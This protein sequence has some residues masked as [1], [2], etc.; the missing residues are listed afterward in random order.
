MY[1]ILFIINIQLHCFNNTP[2]KGQAQGY[3]DHVLIQLIIT[4][5]LSYG[6]GLSTILIW[7]DGV[8]THF[9]HWKCF[10]FV[11]LFKTKFAEERFVDFLRLSTEDW[12]LS[13]SGRL[14]ERLGRGLQNLLQRFESATDLKHKI[15]LDSYE[16]GDF[17]LYWP[18]SLVFNDL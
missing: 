12:W 9:S 6:S 10:I 1:K 16:S 11:L 15:S 2:E 5:L 4:T 3:S 17:Y 7:K 8:K 13:K 18:P 14:A